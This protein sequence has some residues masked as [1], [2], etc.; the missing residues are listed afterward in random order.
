M[1]DERRLTEAQGCEAKAKEHLKTSVWK[2]KTKP[3][4][5]SAAIEYERAAVCYKN[6]GKLDLAVAAHLK[7]SECY[8]NNKNMFHEAKSKESAA[9]ICRDM[10]DFKKA[11]ELFKAAAD[12]YL[13]AGVM[14]T[15]A[16]SIDKAAKLMENADETVA[17]EL[18]E[19]GLTLVQQADKSKLAMNFYQ[20]LIKLFLKAADY[21][22]AKAVSVELIE[23]YKE[24]DALPRIGQVVVG[25]VMMALV[26]DDPI[27]GLNQLLHLPPSDNFAEERSICNNIITAY[28]K[29]DEAKVQEILARGFIRSMDNEYLRLAKLVHVPENKRRDPNSKNDYYVPTTE[30]GEL[31]DG[32]LC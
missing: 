7:A 16:M 13:H 11:G 30:D 5:D 19:F 2:L 12:G 31:E 29:G 15:A 20:R 6:A 25:I 23:K 17:I 10:K 14:D 21:K 32:A 28:E 4:Y 9:F 22:K 1:A 26:V 8:G 24:V 3:D 27:D 18:Y